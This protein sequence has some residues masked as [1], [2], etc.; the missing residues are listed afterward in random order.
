MPISRAAYSEWTDQRDDVCAQWRVRRQ[1]DLIEVGLI[2]AAL[3][4]VAIGIR[5]GIH[6]GATPG[7]VD[8]WYFLASAEAFRKARRFPISLPQYLLHTKTESY[9]PGFILFLALFP[10]SL[11]RRYFWLVSPFIDVVHLLLVYVVTYRLT[12]SLLAATVAGAVHALTPQLIAET[13]SLNPRA[14]GALLASI[15]MY[16]IFRSLVPATDET[17]LLGPSPW[18]VITAAV[19]AATF[20]F[21]TTTGV[22]FFVAT[23]ALSVVFRDA[24]FLAIAFAGLALAIVV[25][26][27]FYIRVLENYVHALR[28]WRRNIRF[29]GLHPIVDSPIYGGGAT[30]ARVVNWQTGGWGHS[31]VRLIGENP[32][33]VP[34][35]FAATPSLP[36]EWWGQRMHVWAVAIIL[37]AFA[38]TFVKPLKIFGPGHLHMKASVMPTAFTLALVVSGQ[39]GWRSFSGAVIGLSFLASAAAIALFYQ[40]LRTRTSEH[41]SSTP[42]DLQLTAADLAAADGDGVLCLPPMYADFLSFAS[43]K[44]V[45]WGGHSGD[46]SKFEALYPVIRRPLDQLIDEYELDYVMLDLAYT[47]PEQLRLADRLRRISG[48]GTFVLYA[49]DRQRTQQ[50]A[51]AGAVWAHN[52]P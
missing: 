35:V 22:T 37:W 36:I 16:L 27:G 24:S 14:F 45:L 12:G 28:F 50:H 34:L 51:R 30:E 3:A 42:P 47:S 6:V 7:G 23:G 11:L 18:Y 19:L 31:L 5:L 4:V 39:D 33:L 13:R 48:H 46:L 2:G 21:L 43:R 32:F 40:Y 38:V 20:L 44:K 49:T 9:P 52:S 15:T 29:R 1:S 26:R 25:S 8:T 41:T 10:P 17:S